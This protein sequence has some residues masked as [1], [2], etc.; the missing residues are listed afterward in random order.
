MLCPSCGHENLDEAQYCSQCAAE[1]EP[2]CPSCQTRNQPGARFCH[3]CREPLSSAEPA[4][5]PTRTPTPTPSPPPPPPPPPAPPASFDG[6]RYQVQRFL[7]EGGRKRVYLAHDTK[8]DRDVAIAV[9]KTEGLDEAGLARVPREAPPIA[10]VHDIG[11]EGGQPY[12]VSQYMAGGDLEGLLQRSENRRLS[13]NQAVL[14][15]N[16]IRQALEQPHGRGII[17][18]D[19]KPGNVWLTE[20]PSAASGQAQTAKLGDFGLAVALDRSRMTQAGMMMGTVAYMPPE[21]ALGREADARS[22]LYSWGC[23][24]YEMVTGRPPF[25]GDDSVAIISQHINTAP[26]APSRH[27]PEGPRAL[28]AL[29]LRCLA[30]NPDERPESAAAIPEAL[31][32]IAETSLTVAQQSVQEANPLDRLAGGGFVGREEGREGA[33]GG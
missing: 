3:R 26:V 10:P 11:D 17:H 4:A 16:Q 19:L 14:I 7:G 29:I 22:D 32:A 2:V 12:I 5:P 28:E 20:A 1:L 18:R 25:L 9:I 24:F 31:G 27:N 15:A 8:L 30:K 21:Q 6:G 33:G 13:I 23:V